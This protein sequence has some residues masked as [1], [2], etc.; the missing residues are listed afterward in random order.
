MSS[1]KVK[2]VSKKISKIKWRAKSTSVFITGSYDDDENS[3]SVWKFPEHSPINEDDTD[4]AADVEP[5]AVVSQKFSGCVTDLKIMSDEVLFASSS[6]GF[7]SMFKYSDERL[8]HSY[9]W[10]KVHKFHQKAA[11]I[12]GIALKGQDIA[13]VGEDGR[14]CIF[15]IVAT[16][17]LQEIEHSDLCSLTAVSYLRH[18]EIVVGNSLGYLRVWDLR[19]SAA[20]PSCLLVLSR[21][22]R[23]VSSMNIHPTQ[24]HI[25]AAGY[26]DGSLCMWDMRQD[27][28]P[29]SLIEGHSSSI[30]ELL[31]HPTNPDFLYTCSMDG[32][33][34]Q[35]DASNLRSNV[36]KFGTP[37][38]PISKKAT[39]GN[40]WLN[41]DANKH[42]L[43]ITSLYSQPFTSVNS[44]DLSGSV[45]IWSADNEALYILN[46]ITV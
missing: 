13:T 42:R 40:P 26:E 43:E 30:S 4:I 20:T 15:N 5:Y 45:L 2:F 12:T 44:L 39:V 29:T 36:P 41:C 25:L 34:W 7:L 3:L 32:S 37:T 6:M 21:D 27:R 23:G 14:L 24:P 38:E 35:W 22:Q 10:E 46:D 19:S 33:L 31:F 28:K 1:V 9:T 17:K 11:S 16:H 18:Q 8:Q